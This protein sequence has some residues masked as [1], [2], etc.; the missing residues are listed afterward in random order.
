MVL[1]AP[2]QDRIPLGTNF[3]TCMC[4]DG[5]SMFQSFMAAVPRFDF[6]LHTVDTM[7]DMWHAD[8]MTLLGPRSLLKTYTQ[9]KP[10]RVKI[11]K[12]LDLNQPKGEFSWCNFGV[13]D[14]DDASKQVLFKS[15]LD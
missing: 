8:D 7:L 13:V 9:A 2:I 12:E 5:N 1:Q 14:P 6:L 11:W 10:S 3:V 4:A 15:R